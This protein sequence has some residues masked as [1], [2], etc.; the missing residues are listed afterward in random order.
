MPVITISREFG[1]GGLVVAKRLSE[2]LNIECLDSAL[3]QEVARRLH[4]AEET[5]ERWDERREGIILRLLRTMQ[6]A[7]PEYSAAPLAGEMIDST[8]DALRIW[9]AESEVIREQARTGNG[10]IVGRAGVHVLAGWPGVLHV[11]LI[12]SEASR[13]RTVASRMGISE[14]EAGRRMHQA[15]RERRLFVKD[16]FGVDW[17]DPHAYA[18]ILKTDE[19]GMEHSARLIAQAAGGTSE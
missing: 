15:D 9:T 13:I 5:V 18:M 14:E 16:R 7:H 10:I 4:V 1:A 2:L 8:P 6:A 12:A 19:L 3:L 17:A 11:R